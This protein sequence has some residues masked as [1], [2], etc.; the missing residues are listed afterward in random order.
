M[1]PLVLRSN[2]Y[3]IDFTDCLVYH[4]KI[5]LDDFLS[6]SKRIKLFQ[7]WEEDAEPILKDTLLVFDGKDNL[8]AS[9]ALPIEE[10]ANFGIQYYEADEFIQ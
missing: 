7:V 5:T 2:F 6:A 1:R 4:Y 8:Y 10:E 9:Q 3:K